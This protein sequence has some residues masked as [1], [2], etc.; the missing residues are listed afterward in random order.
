[1]PLYA[2]LSSA[3]QHRV[4]ERHS[5]RRVVLA[6]NVAETS[7]TVP[8][9]RY[10][11][12][13]GLA[14][15]SRYSVRTKVQ[16]LP[17]EPRQPGLRQP[18]LGPVRPGRGRHRDPA[19]REEDYLARPEFTEPEILRTNLAS[20][21]LQM[22]AL[23]LGDVARFPFVDPPDQR[24]V[25]AGVQLLEEL[26]AL[27]PAVPTAPPEPRPGRRAGP[28]VD[29]LGRQLAALPVDP[30][31][32]RMVVEAGPARLPARGPGDHR[33]DVPAGPA[34]AAGRAPRPRRPAARP[35][36]ATRRRTS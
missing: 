11:V 12:D 15:I 33:G 3:E 7:L 24:N 32:A 34:G 31:L 23:G 19:L 2:R 25:R 16:R 26:G 29:A 9:I 18:A 6:T 28:S 5:R 30:R 4:F 21:I 22:T 8:G 10:V 35:V 27:A 17:I 13:A 20:V 1:M 36:Q 14:R